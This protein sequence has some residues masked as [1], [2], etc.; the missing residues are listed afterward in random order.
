MRHWKAFSYW[1]GIENDDESAEY[2]RFRTGMG[3]YAKR[4]YEAEKYFRRAA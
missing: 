1:S 4:D 2:N 3:L